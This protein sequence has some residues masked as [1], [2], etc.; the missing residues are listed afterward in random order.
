MDK[1]QL[2]QFNLYG[3]S[4]GCGLDDKESVCILNASCNILWESYI[5]MTQSQ[6]N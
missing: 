1:P 2:L 5:G 6:K 4:H 3:N